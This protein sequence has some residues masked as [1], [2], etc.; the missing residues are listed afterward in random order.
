MGL[1]A[2]YIQVNAPTPAREKYHLGVAKRHYAARKL[3]RSRRSRPAW[4]GRK[5]AACSPN[6]IASTAARGLKRKGGASGSSVRAGN[7]AAAAR[8]HQ[9]GGHW[10]QRGKS[11]LP[12]DRVG[13]QLPKRKHGAII[14]SAGLSFGPWFS[15]LYR[16]PLGA[17]PD[18]RFAWKDPPRYL[19]RDRDS[20]Y[21]VPRETQHRSAILSDPG[22]SISSRVSRWRHCSGGPMLVREP[23]LP[24][25]RAGLGPVRH[26]ALAFIKFQ[27]S[28]RCASRRALLHDRAPSV[29]IGLDERASICHRAGLIRPLRASATM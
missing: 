24:Q 4:R 21:G 6:S 25:D 23:R 8:D 5:R 12:T 19:I 1:R 14:E 17:F 7:G 16:A 29:R 10:D 15:R 22:G 13:M 20:A 26:Q 28:G 2:V 27:G 9:G 11:H 18:G 3:G